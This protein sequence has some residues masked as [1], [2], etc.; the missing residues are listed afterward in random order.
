MTPEEIKRLLAET[1]GLGLSGGT[2]AEMRG[3]TMLPQ[4]QKAV[5]QK[6]VRSALRDQ[7]QAGLQQTLGPL[8]MLLPSL[9]LLAE[10]GPGAIGLGQEM[11]SAYKQGYVSNQN[12]D[13]AALA[14]LGFTAIPLLGG[15]GEGKLY[16]KAVTLAREQGIDLKSATP[17]FLSRWAKKNNIK[18][19]EIKAYKHELARPMNPD[20]S[21][22]VDLTGQLEGT[23]LYNKHQDIIGHTQGDSYSHVTFPQIIDELKNQG[24][25]VDPQ[26]LDYQN[27]LM[28]TWDDTKLGDVRHS[29]DHWGGLGDIHARVGIDTQ[30]IPGSTLGILAEVQSDA[31]KK[32]D[33]GILPKTTFLSDYPNVA[34]K[35]ALLQMIQESDAAAPGLPLQVVWPSGELQRKVNQSSSSAYDNIYD[36]RVTK[37]MSE[38]L[39]DDVVIEQ[40]KEAPYTPIR[41]NTQGFDYN[42]EIDHRLAKD[43]AY[44]Q[45]GYT[46]LSNDPE[47]Q[48]YKNLFD[49]DYANP[50]HLKQFVEANRAKDAAS[51]K[52]VSLEQTPYNDSGFRTLTPEEDQTRQ[53]F[54]A[55][56]NTIDSDLRQA[57]QKA[58]DI[59]PQANNTGSFYTNTPKVMP[60]IT[61]ID[62]DG[63]GIHKQINDTY[64]T[65]TGQTANWYS[66]DPLYLQIR[67]MV[68]EASK[69]RLASQVKPPS[70]SLFSTTIPA[71]KVRRLATEGIPL[72][73]LPIGAAM[74]GMGYNS[75]T[76]TASQP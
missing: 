37:A 48:Y 47:H 24:I 61:D 55:I 4:G 9:G 23:P 73:M 57:K 10:A 67:D 64:E 65:L 14:A 13:N 26:S 25:Q 39:G 43:S 19:A 11:G 49:T 42:A 5:Q 33:A 52:A 15:K 6:Q 74:G 75:S 71:E 51:Q 12:F 62:T 8:G 45:L 36:K 21:Y 29:G 44:K 41:I 66:S 34:T 28:K 70:T 3:Q 46:K 22:D 63:M 60:D 72:W 50:E 59:Y 31:A 17:T 27:I 40:M 20:G 68:F 7:A 38:A 32:V 16:S 18:L 35:Q 30:N 2:L 53:Q 56:Y 69:K 54:H 58:A 1:K 76:S